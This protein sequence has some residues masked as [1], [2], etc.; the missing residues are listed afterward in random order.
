MQI[1]PLVVRDASRVGKVGAIA[2]G[3]LLDPL[4][5]RR[6][7]VIVLIAVKCRARSGLMTFAGNARHSF[8]QAVVVRHPQ[9]HADERH[10]GPDR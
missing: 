5:L 9:H 8:Y 10:D 7:K 2:P 6:L 3:T 1:D 4:L